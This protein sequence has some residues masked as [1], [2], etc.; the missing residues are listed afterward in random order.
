MVARLFAAIL[1]LS[2]LS[3]AGITDEV[4]QALEQNNFPAA[5]AEL[6]TYRAQQGLTPDYVEALSW[7][8]RASLA[9]QQLDQADK[10]ARQTET[11]SRQLL[12]KRPLDAEP[13][14]P[15][16]LGA[17]IEVQAQV[18][19]QRGETAQA[20][21]LL[22]RSVE[23]YRGTSIRARLQK[24]LNVLGLTGQPAPPLK[25]T[26]YLGPK[27]VALSQLSGSPVLLFFWA[28]WCVDCKAEGPIIAQLSSEFGSR[29]LML[30]APTQLYG[31]AARGEDAQP[32][33][34][35]PYIEHVWQQYY[36]ALQGVPVPVSK[37]NFNVYGASTT[38]TLVLLDRAG[39]VS[40]YHP[41]AMPYEDLRAA[42]EKA[43][44]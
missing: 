35:F 16:A 30:V 44:R 3:F 42:I 28:H 1:V 8:A 37:E 41:G 23:T 13:H 12:A 7:M 18:L 34:E 31:Y 40:L 32:K 2:T 24:N 26:P 9:S 29:G 38:P 6:Q 22:R 21:A 27:P 11:L 14:L 10:Y 25:I 4:R 5:Q 20:V 17:A 39:R 19:A 36:P 43:F 15:I 33:D